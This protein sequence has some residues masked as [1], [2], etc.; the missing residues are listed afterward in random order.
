[1]TLLA[2]RKPE[3]RECATAGCYPCKVGSGKGTGV[4]E[5]LVKTARLHQNQSSS[6]PSPRE[7]LA[8]EAKEVT[9]GTERKD[10]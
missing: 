6:F 2:G 7:N 10:S 1:M 3:P 9:G 8:D 4:S 5:E